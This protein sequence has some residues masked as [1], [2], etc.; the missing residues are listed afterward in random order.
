MG[1]DL[2]VVSSLLKTGDSGH[3]K[4][5]MLKAMVTSCA[6][7]MLAGLQIHTFTIVLYSKGELEKGLKFY[8]DLIS[9]FNLLKK[10]V[11]D[12]E[13]SQS[14]QED[15][16]Y[17]FYLSYAPDDSH[18]A[19]FFSKSVSQICFRVSFSYYTTLQNNENLCKRCTNPRRAPTIIGRTFLAKPLVWRHQNCQKSYSFS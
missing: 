4:S 18:I 17:D 1:T 15:F 12:I 2:R 6:H 19:S 16:K 14:V 7:W 8:A 11:K 5:A 13:E 10:S 3:S 9:L